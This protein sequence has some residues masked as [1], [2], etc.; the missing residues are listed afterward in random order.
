M[1]L[2]LFF[3]FTKRHM[4]V[5]ANK[6]MCSGVVILTSDNAR[7]I[8]HIDVNS[9]YMSWTAVKFLQYGSELD[10][11]EVPSVIRGNEENRHG[12]VL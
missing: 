10:I 12:I 1:D 11:Q 9:A 6:N 8:F 7:V 3:N 2:L 5:V 4:F